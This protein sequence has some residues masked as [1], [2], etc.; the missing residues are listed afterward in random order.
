M[1]DEVA[2]GP[3]EA[4]LRGALF[5]PN[6]ED[7]DTACKVYNAMIDKRPRM[8]ARCSDVA[9]VISCVNFSREN[10]MLLAVCT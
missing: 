3:F 7:Y 6:D 1:L 5:Q 10:D 2:V 4:S 9:D 8:I